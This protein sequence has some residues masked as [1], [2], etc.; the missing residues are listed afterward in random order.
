MF[1]H[2]FHAG[3]SCAAAVPGI[4]LSIPTSLPVFLRGLPSPGSGHGV[5]PC[6]TCFVLSVCQRQDPDSRV[7]C[8]GARA[9]GR[10]FRAGAVRA[11]DCPGTPAR[12][13]RTQGTGLLS[14]RGGFTCRCEYR[15]PPDD[16]CC[17]PIWSREGE[18][19][20]TIGEVF[21]NNANVTDF[22]CR[23]HCPRPR[24]GTPGPGWLSSGLR[25][26]TVGMSHPVRSAECPKHALRRPG[27]RP[28]APARRRNWAGR[29]VRCR[30]GA[31]SG[32]RT[33][34]REYRPW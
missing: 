23:R 9:R 20:S 33:R 16:A 2:V 27:A 7:M 25:S 21:Q 22:T 15:R 29:P 8:A 6:C 10:T 26:M 18:M 31:H 1:C 5:S 3:R 12:A 30:A 17:R 32:S 24:A 19:S 4:V 11:P 34:R 14:P 13:S 28:A